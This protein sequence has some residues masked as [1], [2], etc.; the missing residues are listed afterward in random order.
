MALYGCLQSVM[1]YVSPC[2]LQ[3]VPDAVCMCVF[4]GGVVLVEASVC[5]MRI[6]HLHC[7]DMISHLHCSV[8]VSGSSSSDV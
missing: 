5:Q 6:S 7:T 2:Y 1:L 4:V 3:F 8:G